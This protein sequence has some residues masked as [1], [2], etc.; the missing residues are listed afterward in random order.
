MKKVSERKRW[1]IL[2]EKSL[3]LGDVVGVLNTRTIRKSMLA[4]GGWEE[5]AEG[6]EGFTGRSNQEGGAKLRREKSKRRRTRLIFHHLKRSR[7]QP[8]SKSE[9]DSEIANAR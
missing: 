9:R 1:A 6:I 3:Q 2:V 7:N 5:Q 4:R 8:S